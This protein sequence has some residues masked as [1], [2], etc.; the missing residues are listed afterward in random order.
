[1]R[2]AAVLARGGETVGRIEELAIDKRTGV[3][4]YAIL[5]EGGLFGIGERYRPL[6]WADLR[7]DAERHA[8]SLPLTRDEVLAI[9]TLEGEDPSG[10][11]VR[12]TAVFI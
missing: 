10:W 11:T 4:A 12:R 8:F 9:P 2:G 1:V 7:Y 3:V 5:G 6:A